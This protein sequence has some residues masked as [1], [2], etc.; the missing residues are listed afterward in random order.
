MREK[1]RKA[2]ASVL[3]SLSRGYDMRSEECDMMA[4][5]CA[6]MSM[7]APPPPPAPAAVATAGV[8]GETTVCTALQ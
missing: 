5:P 2:S 4:A 6:S 3:G 1:S 7:S 8:L